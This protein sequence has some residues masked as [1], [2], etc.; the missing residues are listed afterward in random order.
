MT[1]ATETKKAATAQ[2]KAEAIAL[3]KDSKDWGDENTIKALLETIE[4]QL[5]TKGL[6]ERNYK[7]VA[8]QMQQQG[9]NGSPYLHTRTFKAWRE[10]GRQVR[11]G[12]KSTLFSITWIGTG[13]KE[14]SEDSGRCYPK[15]TNLFHFDQTDPIEGA[16]PSEKPFPS[17]EERAEAQPRAKRSS[18]G[19]TA[20]LAVVQ[21]GVNVTENKDKGGIEIRF[22]A[23]PS[24]DVR[25]QLKSNGFREST[26]NGCWYIKANDSA[27]AFAYSLQA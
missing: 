4:E 10:A 17:R 9:L 8:F 2:R 6:S 19:K 20:G 15:M 11:K 3:W 1:T 26:A 14:G 27:R 25:Q 7:L 13:G 24:Q 18:K 16:I 22:A 5:K 12:E 21:E 23:S